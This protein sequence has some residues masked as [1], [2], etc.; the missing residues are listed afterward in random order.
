MNATTF[1]NEERRLLQRAGDAGAEAR[2]RQIAGEACSIAGITMS[3]LISTDRS[4]SIS[5]IRDTIAFKA[6]AEGIAST[7]IGRA[8]KR[9]HSSIL[10]ALRRERARRMS[11]RENAS[12]LG[13]SA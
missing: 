1:T 11:Q 3:R 10:S 9:D 4:S 12:S 5:K 8:L 7:Q 2:V 6:H 13:Q